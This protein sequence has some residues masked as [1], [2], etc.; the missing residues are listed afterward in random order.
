MNAAALAEALGGRSS[1]H[2]WT[3]HC[4]THVDARPSLSV[5]EGDGG[6]ILIKCHAGCSQGAV[7]K[8]LRKAGLWGRY[9]Q[10]RPAIVR[11]TAVEPDAAAKRRD[12]LRAWRDGYDVRNTLAEAYLWRRGLQL[13]DAEAD[14]LRFH[15]SLWHWP[16]ETWRPAMLALVKLASGEALTVHQTFLAF[17]GAGKAPV[18]KL[19]L[20]PAK[21][22]PAGGGVWFG[23]ADP[24]TEFI[25][26][27]GVETALSAM[28]LIGVSAGCA[29]LSELGIRKLILPPEARRVRVFADCDKAGQSLKVSRIARARWLGEGRDVQVTLPNRTGDDANSILMRRL[30]R[31]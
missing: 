25:V 14:T 8:A 19:R 27:E 12:P 10:A 4:P 29:A 11:K 24:A 7:I 16:T 15:H 3:C 26:A 22:S 31:A 21:T 17:D 6:R 1:G 30:G 2:G 5:A 9:L 18:E 20:F 28:R 13:T 23:V